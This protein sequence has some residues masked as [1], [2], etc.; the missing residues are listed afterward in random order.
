MNIEIFPSKAKGDVTAPASKS[1]AHRLLI[2]AALS[3]GT[4]E[5]KNIVLNDDINATIECLKALGAEITLNETTVTVTGINNTKRKKRL[6]LFCNESG[7]TLRFLIPLS[8][9]FSENTEFTGSGRLM[10]RPQTVFE[11]LFKEKNCLIEKNIK[12]I[13]VSGTLKGGKFPIRGDV[14]SQFI[15]GLLFTLPLLD[16]DSEIILTTPLQS[17]PYINITIDTLKSF[18]IAVEKTQNGYFVNG[19]QS[20]KPQSLYCEGDWSNSAFLHAFNLTGG[21]VSVKGLNDE[22]HQGDA[23]YKEYFKL[24]QNG[25]PTLD[26][27]NCPDLGPVLISC[28]ALLNGATLTGTNRLKIKESDRGEAMAAELLKF[29]CDITVGDDFIKIKKKNLHKPAEAVCCHNDHRIAM[30]MAVVCSVY[31]GVLE[32]A[33]CVNKSYPRFFNDIKDLGINFN[34]TDIQ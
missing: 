33:Q 31:G 24:L 6:N 32:D 29:G 3:N 11:E 15:T 23:V 18:G 30:S 13:N 10:E 4:S 7:S 25:N 26:I 27:S 21:E 9:I 19:K 20:Y 28:A 8:L 16:E 34:N 5:I 14:S 17:E 1:Y 12:A 22:T 2:C